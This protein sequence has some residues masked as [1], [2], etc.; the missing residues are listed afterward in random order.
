VRPPVG[1]YDQPSDRP[2]EIGDVLQDGCL[3]DRL[4]Q[5]GA[6][7]DRE[8]QLAEPVV[9]DGRSG[10]IARDDGAELRGARARRAL[11]EDALDL[12]DV[13]DLEDLGLVERALDAAQRQHRA[14]VEERASHRRDAQAVDVRDVGMARCAAHSMVLRVRA[15]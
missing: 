4:G 1:L 14:E 8:H 15:A 11:V 10:G 6:A 3:A 5:P 2:A 9:R 13:E 7:D 12:G